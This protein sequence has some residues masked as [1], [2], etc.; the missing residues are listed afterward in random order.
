MCRARR[1][2]TFELGS[3]L[4]SGEC[5]SHSSPSL[6]GLG[7]LVTAAIGVGEAGKVFRFRADGF[8][9]LSRDAQADEL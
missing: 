8:I 2:S 6:V 9:L 4:S 7:P 1:P 3:S 5:L